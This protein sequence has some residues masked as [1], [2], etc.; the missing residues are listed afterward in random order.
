MKKKRGFIIKI[1]SESAK[2]K[3]KFFYISSVV[4][5]FMVFFFISLS[6]S[7]I[8][9]TYHFFKFNI[10]KN[11]LSFLEKENEVLRENI[12]LLNIQAENLRKK[13]EDLA[14]KVNKLRNYAGYEPFDEELL[15]IG[16]GGAIL[17]GSKLREPE[18]KLDYMLKLTEKFEEGLREVENYIDTKQRE[19]S[20]IPS[21]M[22]V[23]NGWITSK[24]G[25]RKDPFTGRMKFHKGIDISSRL[26]EPIVATADGVVAFTGW[27]K[28]YGLNVIID[29]GNG[30]RTHYAHLAKAIVKTGQR[31]KRGEIIAL[32]G[33]TGRT[34]GV[35]L[36]Y[37]IRLWGKAVNP[38]NY[39]IPDYIYF[40]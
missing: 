17:P 36:H 23:K 39:I 27:K 31:V 25:R 33:R 12:K 3:Y 21:I 11:R 10:D 9:L 6:V 22:P 2:G 16:K 20:R 7:F 18:E 24:Y 5:K 26:G 28:G 13:I 32:M 19:L 40:E 30:Y 35:H 34:T 4:L 38:M 1:I 37:E 8:F 14:E 15:I 29:H